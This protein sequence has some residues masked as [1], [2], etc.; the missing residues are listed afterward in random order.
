[1]RA[2]VIGHDHI[3]DP[4]YV[5]RVLEAA[6][7]SLHTFTVVPEHRFHAPDVEVR[8]PDPTGWDLVLTLGAPW[9]R[10]SIATWVPREIE[11]LARAHAHGTPILGVCAG[12]QFLA[13]ALGGGHE[14]MG[15]ERVGRHEIRPRVEGIPAGPWFQWH[16]DRITVPPGA[17]V[18]ADSADGPEVFRLG[19]STGVQFHPE[20]SSGLLDRWLDVTPL[21][22]DRAAR[23][24]RDAARYESRAFAR[25]EQLLLTLGH[26]AAPT[27]PGG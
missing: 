27:V 26:H 7:W 6:G 8:F 16:S 19:A 12:A 23:L 17:E 2:L 10:S 22:P 20:M 21:P 5:G 13:E 3:G 9:P 15:S 18:L 25:A 14:P 1:M 11:L 4:G 24:R